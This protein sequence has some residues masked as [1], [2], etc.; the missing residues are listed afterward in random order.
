MEWR[1][2][3]LSADGAE[4]ADGEEPQIAGTEHPGKAVYPQITPITRIQRGG[5]HGVEKGRVIRRWRRAR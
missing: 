5:S 1:R 4:H 2:G 3:E